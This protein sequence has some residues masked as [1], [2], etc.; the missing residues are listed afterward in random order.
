VFQTQVIEKNETYILFPVHLNLTV[1]KKIKP[2]GV[3]T[4]EFL[5][6]MCFSKLAC[7]TINNRLPSMFEDYQSLLLL[8][9]CK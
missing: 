3:N 6:Y 5:C 7:L 2:K 9:I 4:P 8:I 1:F